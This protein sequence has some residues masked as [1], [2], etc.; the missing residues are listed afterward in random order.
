MSMC[1]VATVLDYEPTSSSHLKSRVQIR[2]SPAFGGLSPSV[3]VSAHLNPIPVRT[4]SAAFGSAHACGLRQ[5]PA[6]SLEGQERCVAECQVS[7]AVQ[8]PLC[9]GL[10]DAG[11]SRFHRVA[12]SD[13][14]ACLKAARSPGSS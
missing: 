4:P 5:T 9:T 6:P 12:T 3:W 7:R 8:H 2:A 11:P 10:Q 1:V 13:L 14:M